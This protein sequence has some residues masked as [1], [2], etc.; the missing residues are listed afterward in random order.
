MS[1]TNRG[2]THTPFIEYYTM[3]GSIY[4][5]YVLISMYNSIMCNTVYIIPSPYIKIILAEKKLKI[6]IIN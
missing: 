1:E 2:Y 4:M 5:L 3:Y 6:K